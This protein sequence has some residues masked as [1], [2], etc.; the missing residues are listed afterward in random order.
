MVINVCNFV[1]SIV[2]SILLLCMLMFRSDSLTEENVKF[3]GMMFNI[4]S[5]ILIVFGVLWRVAYRVGVWMLVVEDKIDLEILQ[6][7]DRLDMQYLDSRKIL[8]ADSPSSNSDE[9]EF[10]AGRL[11]ENDLDVSIEM[12]KPSLGNKTKRIPM[13]SRWHYVKSDL[14]QIVESIDPETELD[15][16]SEENALATDEL[17]ESITSG[18]DGADGS[19]H[20]TVTLELEEYNSV[21]SLVRNLEALGHCLLNYEKISNA[22]G[23]SVL[24]LT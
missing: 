7:V 5:S 20:W 18:F 17:W 15:N 6:L 8:G 4:W 13:T 3:L 23:Q 22:E 14:P 11:E 19:R 9:E 10:R 24:N 16:S 12:M 1:E 2:Y 21:F